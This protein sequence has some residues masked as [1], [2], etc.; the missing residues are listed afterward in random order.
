MFHFEMYQDYFIFRFDSLLSGTPGDE[1]NEW[2][3]GIFQINPFQQLKLSKEHVLSRGLSR[4]CDKL[5]FVHNSDKTARNTLHNLIETHPI[6]TSVCKLD[7]SKRGIISLM[8]IVISQPCVTPFSKYHNFS[9]DFGEGLQLYSDFLK[10]VAKVFEPFSHLTTNKEDHI[11]VRILAKCLTKMLEKA[12]F[13]A[14]E[15]LTTKLLIQQGCSC[16]EK[17]TI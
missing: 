13:F 6:F 16:K 4:H 2:F 7:S 8:E 5:V 3:Y 9:I 1:N 14:F 15:I 10:D 12:R 17:P 11:P